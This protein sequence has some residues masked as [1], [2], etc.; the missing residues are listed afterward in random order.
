MNKKLRIQGFEG[1]R[2]QVETTKNI[3]DLIMNNACIKFPVAKPWN[4]G[5]LESSNP[6]L[7]KLL[8]HPIKGGKQ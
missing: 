5:T 4:P 2:I 7:P 3:K 8:T 1:S 6:L